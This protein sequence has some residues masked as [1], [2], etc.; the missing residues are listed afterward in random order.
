MKHPRLPYIRFFLISTIVAIICFAKA[1][2]AK[3]FPL[4]DKLKA[5]V[6]DC[7]EKVQNAI[8]NRKFAKDLAKKCP[9]SSKLIQW[10]RY[11][12]DKRD[13]TFSEIIT[14]LK[15]NPSWP[16]REQMQQRA[17]EALPKDFK[18]SSKNERKVALAW[19]KKKAPLTGHGWAYYGYLLKKPGAKLHKDIKKAWE[20]ETFSPEGQAAFLKAFKHELT[21][22]DH[23]TRCGRLL[24]KDKLD[25]VRT[26][27]PEL[28]DE[29]RKLIKVRLKLAEEH[30]KDLAH[31]LERITPSQKKKTSI[32]YEKI[33]WNVAHKNDDAA[34]ALFSA[35]PSARLPRYR[36]A[37]WKYRNLLTRRLLEAKRYHEAYKVVRPHGLTNGENFASGEWLAG[38]IALHFLKDPRTARTHFELLYTNVSSP[39]SKSRA[40]FWIG[41]AETALKQTAEAKLWYMQAANYPTTFYGQLATSRLH[42]KPKKLNFSPPVK[43]PETLKHFKGRIEVKVIQLLYAINRPGT[44][45]RFLFELAQEVTD[46]SEAE[47][48]TEFAATYRSTNIGVWVAVKSTKKHVPLVSATYPT[49]KRPHLKESLA[50]LVH[51]IIRQESRFGPKEV[52]NKGAQGMMQLLPTTAHDVEKKFHIHSGSLFNPEHNVLVGSKYLEK[53][54]KHYSGNIILAS[55]AYNSGPTPVDRWIKEVGDP[56]DSN[57]DPIHWIESIEYGETRNYVQRIIEA[58]IV[59]RQ[60][61]G[62][63][64]LDLLK[65]LRGQLSEEDS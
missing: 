2:N 43:T 48:L 13:V 49:I 63:E 21:P 52:S 32:L 50:P 51:A 64:P 37:L 40:A 47:L 59:Y 61:L 14:F 3:L 28:K 25:Q 65:V 17:E 39:L 58:Y 34:V 24:L 45:D 35:F 8:D 53:L 10:L 54:L 18:D 33:R 5:E 9:L 15:N 23:Y 60:R 19:F 30:V 16:S 41:E 29:Q 22:K 62:Q 57:V 44:M 27:L 20:E 26:L 55:A 38:W 1:A 12:S 4:S 42:A 56:R 46:R 31:I 7:G 6:A 11:T 36:D